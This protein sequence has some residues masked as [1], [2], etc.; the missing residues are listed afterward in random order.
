MTSATPTTPPSSPTSNQPGGN[1]PID[2]TA[3]ATP[4]SAAR[5]STGRITARRTWC[6]VEASVRS[7]RRRRWLTAVD[8]AGNALSDMGILVS[9][10]VRLGV[11]RRK[12]LARSVAARRID[13]AVDHST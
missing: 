8:R 4:S 11:L 2:Q 5:S 6:N 13:R 3:K 10:K 9:G 12:G 7:D 1:A